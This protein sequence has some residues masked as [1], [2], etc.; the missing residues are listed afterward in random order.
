MLCQWAEDGY[1]KLAIRLDG[2]PFPC[3]GR[4]RCQGLAYIEGE[5][6]DADLLLDTRF[7]PPKGIQLILPGISFHPSRQ[8]TLLLLPDSDRILE[9]KT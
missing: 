9:R 1:C 2:K 6:P 7:T 8:P 4:A 5:T 3:D